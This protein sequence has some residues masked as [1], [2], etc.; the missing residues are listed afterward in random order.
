[1]DIQIGFV[2]V[3]FLHDLFTAVWIG[4]LIVLGFAVLPSIRKHKQLGIQVKS[5][6]DSIQKRLNIVVLVSIIGL[7]LTGFLL[8]NRADAFAG[9]LNTSNVYSMVLAAK[10]ALVILMTA[11]ATFR[12]VA[13]VRSKKSK[14]DN[15][16]KL[17]AILLV[18]NI[19]LGIIVLFLSAY[20]AAL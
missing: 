12:T 8:A 5:I 6:S 3:R 11:I 4:G 14:N 2:L 9:F 19:V 1:M 20:S 16:E 7:W 18:M 10:H 13:I 15:S 17:G